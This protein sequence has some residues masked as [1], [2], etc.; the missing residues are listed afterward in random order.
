[1]EVLEGP[2]VEAIACLIR[3]TFASN[4]YV[5]P[6]PPD[7]PP[8]S[9]EIIEAVFS[10]LPTVSFLVT[11]NDTRGITEALHCTIR[12]TCMPPIRL[13]DDSMQ[14]SLAL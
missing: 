3:Q 13:L 1:M 12:A 11:L 9:S 14:C 4:T 6:H 2:A 5:L 10:S 7:P 8:Q